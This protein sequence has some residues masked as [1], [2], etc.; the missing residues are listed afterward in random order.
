MNRQI[1]F[2][3]SDIGSVTSNSLCEWIDIGSNINVK[4]GMLEDAMAEEQELKM[5]KVLHRKIRAMMKQ[6]LS[7]PTS[8]RRLQ[9]GRC[10]LKQR[11]CTI[12][13]VSRLRLP[14]YDVQKREIELERSVRRGGK[15]RQ[16]LLTEM[17]R[18]RK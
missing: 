2:I 1:F 9:L 17:L 18:M 4:K 8:H 12:N 7:L 15:T 14:L 11:R 3:D 10:Y 13:V 16:L 5:F 6:R